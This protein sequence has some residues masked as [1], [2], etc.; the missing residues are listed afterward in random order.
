MFGQLGYSPISYPLEVAS[1]TELATFD[2]DAAGVRSQ[3]GLD[4]DQFT[5]FQLA[6][7]DAPS[8]IV[9]LHSATP[10][11]DGN[12]DNPDARASI[13]L[14]SFRIAPSE[15]LDRT[16]QA[17]LRL[18]IG[19]DRSSPSPLDPLFWSI[20]A[21]LDLA[22]Q[23][24]TAPAESKALSS[25]FS[26]AFKRRPIEIPGGLAELRVE[27]VAHVEPPWWRRIFSFADNASVRK[28]VAAIGFP[29]I[30]LD[31][32]QLLDT[33]LGRFDEGK[34]KPIFRSR[35]LTVALTKRAAIDFSGGL[36]SVSAAVLN[37]GVFLMLRHRDVSLLK[38]H[39]PVYLG[40][41]GRLVPKASWDPAA[42]KPPDDDPYS[43]L[44]YAVLRV[45]TRAT[46][47]DPGL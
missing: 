26:K 32:V 24:V 13:D 20:A 47:L 39:P 42:P 46:R 29:G 31:A 11:L 44:S 8:P 19:K 5:L 27:V 36:S 33:M 28:L 16:M 22:A 43:D 9:D 18:D 23:A 17:T 30:A 37:D 35:P 38:L 34:A 14:L 41:Y 25:D 12:D 2:A 10:T 15:H 40:G 6:G 45:K 1:S 4:P 21:G 3:P 7:Q